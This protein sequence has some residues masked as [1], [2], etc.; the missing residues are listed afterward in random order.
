M[1]WSDEERA[2]Y[3]WCRGSMPLFLFGDTEELP[4]AYVK[5]MDEARATCRWLLDMTYPQYAQ[6]FWLDAHAPFRSTKRQAGEQDA[7]LKAR[8]LGE[9]NLVTR[10]ALIREADAILEAHGLVTGAKMINVEME[11]FFLDYSGLDVG[12]RWGNASNPQGT[13]IPTAFVLMLPYGTTAAARAAITEM[14]RR[15]GAAGYGQAVEVRE[16]P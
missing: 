13:G 4:E 11:G 1:A 9:P 7:Q 16:V 2:L 5:I 14:L 3:D 6:G 10:V 12:E 8:L 15:N